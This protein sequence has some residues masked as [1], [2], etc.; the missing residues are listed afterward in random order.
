[1][2]TADI[3]ADT[4]VTISTAKGCHEGS[5]A[6]CWRWQ[7]SMQGAFASI[8]LADG[9][10]VDVDGFDFDGEDDADDAVASLVHLIRS[11]VAVA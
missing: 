10:D 2:T 9:T 7:C 11:V 5:I 3:T 1:M 4:I 8:E 6:D